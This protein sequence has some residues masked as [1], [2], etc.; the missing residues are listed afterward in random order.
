MLQVRIKESFLPRHCKLGQ[1][2]FMGGYLHASVD[3]RDLRELAVGDALK[4]VAVVTERF[5]GEKPHA[6]LARKLSP[7][8]IVPERK[9]EVI[10]EQPSAAFRSCVRAWTI[11]G[12]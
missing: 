5:K 9:T 6:S 8:D 11:L 2:Q 3:G 4:V 10:L 12:T 1:V 7:D